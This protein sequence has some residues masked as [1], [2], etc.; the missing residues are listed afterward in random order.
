MVINAMITYNLNRQQF[1]SLRL[2]LKE[3]IIII[4]HLQNLNNPKTSATA[5][6]WSILKT[7]YN[8]KKIPVIPS[9]LINNELISYCKMKAN[10]FNSFFCFPMYPIRQQQYNTR[11]SN[12]YNRQ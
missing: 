11:E 8:G 6:Y 9:L 2:L 10:N 1:L 7:S 3:K 5:S 12:L 4:S